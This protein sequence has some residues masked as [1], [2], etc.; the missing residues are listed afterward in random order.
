MD[1]DDSSWFSYSGLEEKM[2]VI[3]LIDELTTKKDTDLR[4]DGSYTQK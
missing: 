2:K 1:H 4:V 3:D